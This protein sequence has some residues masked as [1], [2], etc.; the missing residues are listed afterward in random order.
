MTSNG[1]ASGNSDLFYSELEPFYEFGEFVELDAYAPLPDDWM[2]IISDVQG[3]RG[4]SRRDS[5]RK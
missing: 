3:S 1:T 2:V 5:T 4:L